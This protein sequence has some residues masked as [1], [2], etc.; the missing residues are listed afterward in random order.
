M[1]P[2]I[3]TRVVSR[4]CF[5]CEVLGIAN[6]QVLFTGINDIIQGQRVLFG[7]DCKMEL[8]WL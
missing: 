2:M 3:E 6:A 5:E 4:L 1:A 8:L 7:L